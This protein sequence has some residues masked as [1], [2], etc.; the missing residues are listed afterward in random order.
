MSLENKTI[1][2][3]GSTRGIGREIALVSA[4]KGANIV[5]TGKTV[6]PHPKLVGTLT[7]VREEIEALGAPVIAIPLD[8][9]EPTAIQEMVEKV[10]QRFGGIDV[11]VNNASAINLTPTLATSVKQFDLMFQV[12]LRG[13]FFCSQACV[14][15]LKQSQNGHILNMAPPLN[16]RPRWFQH[17]VAY[18]MSKYGMS[19]C[20]LGMAEE[21]RSMGIAVNALW[22]RTTIG[23]A[24]IQN[25]FPKAYVASRVPRIVADAAVQIVQEDAKQVTGQFFIDETYLA[26]KGITDFSSYAIKADEALQQ[27][28]FLD[29]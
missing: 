2:I 14:P 13:T 15:Y 26:S 6:A 18:T 24:A 7:S 3:V 16:L 27:D 4:Q 8:V 10:V 1:V 5:I 20:T 22:P 9:R 25:L 23:T 21:F 17:H 28:F 11:L 12:N 19:M 29:D